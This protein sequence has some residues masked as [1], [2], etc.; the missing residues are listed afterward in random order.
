M[1]TKKKKKKTTNYEAGRHSSH[2]RSEENGMHFILGCEGTV[3]S[4]KAITND[5]FEMIKPQLLELKMR[6]KKQDSCVRYV[7]VD[8]CCQSRGCIQDVFSDKTDDGQYKTSVVQDIKHLINRPL[9]MINK[10]H[11]LYASFVADFHGA[12]TDGGKKI[13]V[14]SRNGQWANV[15]APL[16]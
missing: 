13:K 1:D 10:T 14:K 16:D 8:N 2:V 5:S 11:K 12:V 4:R 6:A 9:E 7:V 15:E 3:L